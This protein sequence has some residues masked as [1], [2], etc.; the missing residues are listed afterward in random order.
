MAAATS[1]LRIPEKRGPV[2]RV[3]VSS[4][5]LAICAY[6]LYDTIIGLRIGKIYLPSRYSLGTTFFRD[7]DPNGFW[8]A[9]A[10]SFLMC[11]ILG[12]QSIRELHYTAKRFGRGL[13]MPNQSTDPTFSSG[14]SRAGHEPRHR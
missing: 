13:E 2:L 5:F 3:I 11:A 8:Y 1:P 6:I 14:T 4:L 12:V 10:F 9:V 7:K